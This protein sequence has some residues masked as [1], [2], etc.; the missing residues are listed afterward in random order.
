MPEEKVSMGRKV[1][2]VRNWQQPSRENRLDSRVDV[3]RRGGNFVWKLRWSRTFA[4]LL[5]RLS[6]T[7]LEAQLGQVDETFIR[8]ELLSSSRDTCAAWI[9]QKLVY[10]TPV[11]QSVT[12]KMTYVRSSTF[13]AV[14]VRHSKQ[15]YVENASIAYLFFIY[16]LED[17]GFL[18]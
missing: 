10:G 13:S 12:N 15:F 18:C 9:I 11:P 8:V 16:D 3:F 1:H 6:I 4:M 14:V 5:A 2:H 7:Y 17:P